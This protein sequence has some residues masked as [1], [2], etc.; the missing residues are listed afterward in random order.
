MTQLFSMS[1]LKGLD[2]EL[3]KLSIAKECSEASE[4]L[5]ISVLVGTMSLS[6]LAMQSLRKEREC[7]DDLLGGM[8]VGGS[9]F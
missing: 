2:S 1:P 3:V 9:R 4:M 8:S 6:A 5:A 7:R